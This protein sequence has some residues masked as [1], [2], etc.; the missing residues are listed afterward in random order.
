M[1]LKGQEGNSAHRVLQD[2][3]DGMTGE[4]SRLTLEIENSL[5][6]L[7]APNQKFTQNSLQ[8]MKWNP[9]NLE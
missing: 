8:D 3:I 5:S 7:P 1:V 9:R 2:S 4:A 6:Q